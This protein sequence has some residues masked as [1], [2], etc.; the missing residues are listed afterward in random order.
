MADD[1]TNFSE[2]LRKISNSL[3]NAL[4]TFGPSSIQAHAILNMLKDCLHRLN[5]QK[6][7]TAAEVDAELLN[8]AMGL[9]KLRE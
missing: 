2:E 1:G 7:K 5:N 6:L 8:S 3:E 4:D 9:L